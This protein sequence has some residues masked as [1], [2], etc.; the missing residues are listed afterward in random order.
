MVMG[1]VS[2]SEGCGFESQNRILDGHFFTFICCKS[3][4]EKTKLNKK[5]AGNDPFKNDNNRRLLAD[6]KLNL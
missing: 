3:L 6:F 4:F 5:E 2:S 1:E